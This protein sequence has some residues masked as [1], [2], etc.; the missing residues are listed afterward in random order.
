MSNTTDTM[1]KYE[2][3]NAG[4]GADNQQSGDPVPAVSPAP[5]N[6]DAPIPQATPQSPA[7]TEDSPEVK[8]EN[9][10]EVRSQNGDEGEGLARSDR[11]YREVKGESKP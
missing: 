10:P 5:D 11:E 3:N 7:Q 6:H 4:D 1:N 9:S 8:E 2:S